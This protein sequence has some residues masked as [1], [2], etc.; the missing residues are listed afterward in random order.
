MA[1]HRVAR[2]ELERSLRELVREGRK[3]DAVNQDGD[4]WLVITE[5]RIETRAAS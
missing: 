1:V 5:D 3:V 2:D 4:D